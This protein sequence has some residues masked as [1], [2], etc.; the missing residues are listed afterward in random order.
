MLGR[1]KETAMIGVTKNGINDVVSSFQR[2]F[3]VFGEG[4]VEALKLG[5]ETLRK[6]VA[7]ENFELTL[8]PTSYSSFLPLFG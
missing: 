7:R 1:E 8:H 6:S 2:R 4:D 5:G 3:K